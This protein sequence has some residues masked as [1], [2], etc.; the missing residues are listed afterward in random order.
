[1][2]HT[3]K[4][5][6]IIL[7]VISLFLVLNHPAESDESAQ[8]LTPCQVTAERYRLDGKQV[9]L[10]GRYYLNPHSSNDAPDL[11]GNISG[12]IPEDNAQ[13]AVTVSFEH[14]SQSKESRVFQKYREDLVPVECPPR[15]ICMPPPVARYLYVDIVAVG[16][17]A[18]TSKTRMG[19]CCTLEV[20]DILS[21]KLGPL[22]V[23]HS[24]PNK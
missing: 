21:T 3:V 23:K 19:Y 11:L 15:T 20:Q 13:P 2:D 12:C 18:I 14:L 5:R 8:P 6:L 1:M 4:R 16:R 9:A 22:N 10:S 24:P 7:G 17:F